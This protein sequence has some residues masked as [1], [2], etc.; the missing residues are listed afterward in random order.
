MLNRLL[1]PFALL[2]AA[3]LLAMML[4]T[5]VDVVGRYAFDAP[6][7]GAGEATEILLA[8]VVFAGLP[9]ASLAGEHI[10]IDILDVLLGA[11]AQRRQRVLGSVCA[12][13]GC[14]LL[15]WRLWL[16][17]NELMDYGDVAS[18]LKIPLAPLAWF[19][20]LCCIVAALAFAFIAWRERRA[21]RPE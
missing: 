5:V 17:G 13:A 3:A 19:M 2:G 21:R 12:A 14:G 6:L 18:H 10:R 11:R 20:A 8:L 16:R 9:L 1:F 7:G 15:A 4:L